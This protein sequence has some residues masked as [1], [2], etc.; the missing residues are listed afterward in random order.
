MQTNAKQ[1][2]IAMIRL[3]ISSPPVEKRRGLIANKLILA[4]PKA[5]P[6]FEIALFCRKEALQRGG[7][8]DRV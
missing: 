2:R 7:E 8:A 1:A 3:N 4:A 6:K 5:N